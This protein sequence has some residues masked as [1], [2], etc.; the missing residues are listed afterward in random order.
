M[1]WGNGAAGAVPLK[2]GLL[3][4]RLTGREV[5]VLQQTSPSP[6]NSTCLQHTVGRR[7]NKLAFVV[8]LRFALNENWRLK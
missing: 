7:M 3:V 5:N 6:I 1:N 2:M 4:L 8:F